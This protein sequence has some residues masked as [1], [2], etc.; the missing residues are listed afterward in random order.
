MFR[1]YK[2]IQTENTTLAVD[3]GV[4][5]PMQ[6]GFFISSSSLFI[7]NF[8]STLENKL[9]FIV[10]NFVGP[11]SLVAVNVHHVAKQV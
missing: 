4:E 2:T 5:S 11:H 9:I 8:V 6:V 3:C 7:E 1:S 10:P